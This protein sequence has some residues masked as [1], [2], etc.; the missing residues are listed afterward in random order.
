M[1]AKSS[2]KLAPG[3]E[4][5]W[6]RRR[7]NGSAAYPRK[8]RPGAP[9]EIFGQHCCLHPEQTRQLGGGRVFSV[10]IKMKGHIQP[11]AQQV[12]HALIRHELW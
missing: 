12:Q 5:A 10:M 1:I 3:I 8:A 2:L 6:L 11:S 4:A 7:R 9:I